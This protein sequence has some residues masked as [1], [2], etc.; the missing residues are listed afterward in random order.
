MHNGIIEN[1]AA[2]KS[3]LE[4]KGVEFY[5]QTDSEVLANLI[6]Y[7]YKQ[8]GN[9][10][11]SVRLAL[12]DATGAYGLA[13]FASDNPDELIATKNGSPLILGIAKHGL[14]IASDTA[15]IGNHTTDIVY[16]QDGEMIILDK[17]KN[18]TI[19]TLAGD[20]LEKKIEKIEGGQS[21]AGK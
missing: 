6:A 1:Y 17:E 15:A 21:T 10:R 2:I 7:Y 5:G 18:Y 14:I 13:V 8:C 16:M 12:A 19:E 4:S 3:D 20:T 9:L 11:E